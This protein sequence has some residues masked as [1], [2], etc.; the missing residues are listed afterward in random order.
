MLP[1]PT[2][3][4]QTRTLDDHHEMH[5]GYAPLGTDTLELDSICSY[6]QCLPNAQEAQGRSSLLC[7]WRSQA[8]QRV[9]RE[10]RHPVLLDAIGCRAE[11]RPSQ[12]VW[13]LLQR[14]PLRVRPF[15]SMTVAPPATRFLHIRSWCLSHSPLVVQGLKFSSVRW[16]SRQAP[17]TTPP[18]P[19]LPA[20]L[21]Q[22]GPSS[23]DPA[24]AHEVG[25]R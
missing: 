21:L 13:V 9:D 1:F 23:P 10:R 25:M 16:A 11:R 15:M 4:P 2:T 18:P 12:G 5:T 17:L 24:A 14:G 22:E 8:A 3:L 20:V 6:V 19:P 7:L